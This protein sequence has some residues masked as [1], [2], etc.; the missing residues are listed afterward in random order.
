MDVQEYPGADVAICAAVIALVKALV[1]E[2]WSSLESQ[3]QFPTEVLRNILD[4]VTAKAECAEITS[5]EFLR[6]FDYPG[7]RCQARDL[8]A[9]LFGQIQRT[10]ETLD[11]LFAPLKLIADHGTLATRICTALGKTFSLED[12]KDVYEEL[13]DSLDQWEPFRP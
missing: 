4:D 2:T 5:A 3:K 6:L 1:A 8:W 10:D 9:H 12:L 13:S 7:E 11:S